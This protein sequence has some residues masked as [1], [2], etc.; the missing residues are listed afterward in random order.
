MQ[1][2][3]HGISLVRKRTLETEEPLTIRTCMVSASVDK[4]MEHLA[5]FMVSNYDTKI[6]Y[7]V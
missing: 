1:Q 5:I 7:H 3:D 4:E 2:L 6:Q